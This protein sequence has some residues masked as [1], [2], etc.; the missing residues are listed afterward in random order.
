VR[1]CL[2][3]VIVLATC[4][5]AITAQ[6]HPVEWSPALGLGSAAD[7]GQA[8]EKPFDSPTTVNKG[9]QSAV[10]SNCNQYL[11][12]RA[13]GFAARSDRDASVLKSRG[14]DCQALRALRQAK[15]ARVSHVSDFHLDAK[16]PGLLPA[17]LAPSLSSDEEQTVKD[18]AARGLSWLD[19]QPKLTSKPGE[20]Q[21]SVTADD[22]TTKLEIYGRGDFNNDGIED[23]LIR[24]DVSLAAGSYTNSRLF[25]LTREKDEGRLRLIR[26]YK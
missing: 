2:T 4:D 23:I 19:Y 17:T 5:G 18:A 16:A 3:A 20:R 11:K 14:V 21:L 12:Y 9:T 15:P 22:T 1:L 13:L 25:L 8:L 24:A 10:V 26:E 7:I 6:T